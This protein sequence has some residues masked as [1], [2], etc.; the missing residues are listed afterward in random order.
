MGAYSFNSVLRA[1]KALV[2]HRA[3]REAIFEAA[4]ALRPLEVKAALARR[5]AHAPPLAGV[6]ALRRMVALLAIRAA[7]ERPFQLAT[8][9]EARA[10]LEAAAGER[11]GGGWALPLGHSGAGPQG[12]ELAGEAPPGG[13]L[14][15][16]LV[17][18]G[19]SCEP[20]ARALGRV[21]R[22]RRRRGGPSALFRR[23]AYWRWQ[24]WPPARKWALTSRPRRLSTS[25][26]AC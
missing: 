24:W 3:T 23:A 10:Y 2:F 6:H 17:L 21:P 25:E 18:L 4:T 15:G 26:A 11:Q 7:G 20:P 1:F 9:R 22:A 5:A 13:L 8:D 16:A 14:C 12:K 19:L